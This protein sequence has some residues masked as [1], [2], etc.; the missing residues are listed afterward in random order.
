MFPPAALLKISLTLPAVGLAGTIVLSAVS[1]SAFIA[2]N[3]VALRE[4]VPVLAGNK[5]I[6]SSSTFKVSLS[7]PC[8]VFV[9]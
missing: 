5:S 4:F 1:D 2:A 7:A 8:I 9:I 3:A 6:L